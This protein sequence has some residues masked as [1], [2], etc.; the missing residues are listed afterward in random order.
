MKQAG[1]NIQANFSSI[2]FK[3]WKALIPSLSIRYQHFDTRMLKKNEMSPD[4]PCKEYERKKN[5]YF[6][7]WGFN[8]SQLDAAYYGAVSGVK[9]DYYVTRSM[10]V[11]YIYPYL[12]RYDFVPAYMD[13]NVQKSLLRLP[14]SSIDVMTTEDVVYNSNGVYYAG[15]GREIS[16]TEAID[17]LQSYGEAT[18]LKPSVETYGG[19]GVQKVPAGLDAVGYKSLFKQYRKDFIFQRLVQQHPVMSQFNPTSVNTL[20]VVTYRKPNR[21][22]KILY[23]CVR[24]GGEG[25]VMDNV[26]S[27]GGFTGID[28]ETGKLRD[29]KRYCYLTTSIPALSNSIPNEIP[30]WKQIKEVALALH[31]RLPQL[32]IIG[33]DFA[34]SPEGK[35]VLIEFNPRPGV[36]LQVA[37]GPMFSKEDLD[38]L[39]AHVSKVKA[40]YIALG[41]IHFQDKPDL[42]TV[43]LKFGELQL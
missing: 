38:E 6:K 26:C 4:F 27:G 17:I 22:R 28:I 33:W 12:D 5:P 3:L 30:Y 35:P 23:S 41:S 8:V 43:H 34:I 31:G 25:S 29:R 37:V 20:R 32:D 21:E 15:D 19:H 40:D 10:A 16:E 24:Y 13:K 36:G 9:A 18:I 42:R 39:M 7:K 1:W 11:H 14:D 2:A